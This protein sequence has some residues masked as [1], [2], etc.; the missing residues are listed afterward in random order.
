M[1]VLL[2]LYILFEVT[3]LKGDN[4]TEVSSA[5]TYALL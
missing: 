2:S 5:W 1:L 4:P 3:Y